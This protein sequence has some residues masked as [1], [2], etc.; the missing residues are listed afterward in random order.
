M[1]SSTAA[2]TAR[3]AP[4]EGAGRVLELIRGGEA[5]TIS[6]LA[7][8]MGMARSTVLQ[9]L[10]LL[11][12]QGLVASQ[13]ATKGGRGRP[14]ALSVFDPRAAFVFAA[15]LGVTGYRAATTDLSGAVL[16]HEFI[17]IDL[18]S[19]PDGLADALEHSFKRLVSQARL[20]DR[21]LAGIG[22]G[23]PRSA[24]LHRY[25]RSADLD[26]AD[27]DRRHFHRVLASRHDV[28]V[29]LD[30]DVNLLAL[31]ERRRSWPDT[32]VFV[33]A[34]LGTV[35]DAA[36]V[37]QGTP[38]RGVSGMAGELAHVKV[39]GS[40]QICTCGGHGCLEAVAGGAALVRDLRAAGHQVD[41]ISQVV[42]MANEGE[43][44]AVHAVRT[45]GRRIGQALAT[46]A[47]LLNP[48]VIAVWGYLVDAETILFSGIR[49]GLYSGALPDASGNLTLA[50]ASLGELAGALG[51]A[52]L[53][54]DEVLAPA[55]VDQIVTNQSWKASD[56]ADQPATGT[57][58]RLR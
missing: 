41:H 44:D 46:V 6:A 58:P 21:P 54:I 7:A 34:K 31:A 20:A 30:T 19:G 2:A 11:I 28:P 45:A 3:S 39:C 42:R 48:D 55:H 36:V 15:H 23:V 9:R 37:V 14:A 8:R 33:C 51:A 4:A 10:S 32:E 25:L 29:Y 43:P 53:V 18:G 17:N 57:A 22:V 12:D 1:A 49:E 13:T 16:A 52:N 26:G 35:I 27:W 38:V 40:T 50:T 47:N 5:Q 24:E 56:T